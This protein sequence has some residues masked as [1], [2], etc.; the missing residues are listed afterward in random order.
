MQA[1]LEVALGQRAECWDLEGSQRTHA[2]HASQAPVVG[3][4]ADLPERYSRGDVYAC[5]CGWV[6]D[7]LLV[8]AQVKGEAIKHWKKCQG[9]TPPSLAALDAPERKRMRS[10]IQE[11]HASRGGALKA[12]RAAEV[13]QKWFA[14]LPNTQPS[15]VAAACRPHFDAPVGINAAG[16]RRYVCDKC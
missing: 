1:V 13:A 15:L 2:S 6:P 7:A 3:D 4:V 12:E 8:S 16:Q 14:E 11:G 10:F 9:S 5:P